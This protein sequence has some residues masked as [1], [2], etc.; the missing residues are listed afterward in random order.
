M[1]S[2]TELE[3]I[4]NSKTKISVKI[5]NILNNTYYYPGFKNYDIP[6]VGRTYF[7]RFIHYI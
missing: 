6:C 7:F 1:I 3:I 5:E 4:K 2:T